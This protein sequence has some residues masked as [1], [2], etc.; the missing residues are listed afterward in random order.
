MRNTR[1]Q[2]TTKKNKGMAAVTK[3]KS[4]QTVPASLSLRQTPNPIARAK[5]H[6][7]YNAGQMLSHASSSCRRMLGG[8][9]KRTEINKYQCRRYYTLKGCFLSLLKLKSH[10][11]SRKIHHRIFSLIV[12]SFNSKVNVCRQLTS[13]HCSTIARLFYVREATKQYKVTYKRWKN[14]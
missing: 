8:R 9:C 12:S 4:N 2:A 1:Y 13:G 5:G 6:K 11:R 10:A 14:T 7:D 3:T